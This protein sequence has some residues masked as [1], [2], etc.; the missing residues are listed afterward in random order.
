MSLTLNYIPSNFSNRSNHS[1]HWKIKHYDGRLLRMKS[2]LS[3]WWFY[4][5]N[6]SN[7]LKRLPHLEHGTVDCF[8]CFLIK[9]CRGWDWHYNCWPTLHKSVAAISTQSSYSEPVDIHTASVRPTT[10][11]QQDPLSWRISCSILQ[12][13]LLRNDSFQATP[14]D[15]PTLPFTDVSIQNVL[16]VL[17]NEVDGHW[18]ETHKKFVKRL[19][20]WRNELQPCEKNRLPILSTPLGMMTS[21]YFLVWKKCDSVCIKDGIRHGTTGTY[22]LITIILTGKQNSSKAGLTNVVYWERICSRSRPLFMS[23]RTK[24]KMRSTY[25]CTVTTGILCVMETAIPLRDSLTS[26]SVSTKSFMWN[27]LRTFWG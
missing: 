14:I 24:G 19:R 13:A 9:G 11:L 1:Q 22:S 12:V 18:C 23:R 16:D 8:F 21:A 6:Y 4:T 2:K 26:E 3:A 25:C 27:I 5:N 17:H 20:C 10:G 15:G 7:I